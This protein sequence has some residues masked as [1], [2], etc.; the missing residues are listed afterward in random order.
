M[1]VKV[2][3]ARGNGWLKGI[4]AYDGAITRI[5]LPLDKNGNLV[6]GLNPEDEERLEKALFL[7]KGDLNRNSPFWTTKT[8][9]IPANQILILDTDTPEHELDYLILKAQRKVAKSVAELNTGS[10]ASCEFV[11]FNDDEEA[12]SENKRG[13]NKRMAYALFDT[14]SPNEM[15]DIL[16]VYGKPADS[17]S[18]DVV[19]SQL[20]KLLE[21]DPA[22]FLVH[23]NDPTK[24]TRVF[25]LNLVRAGILAK[26]GP[27]YTMYGTD[28]IL[29]YSMEEL[30]KYLDAKA[31][32]GKLLELKE[33]LKN[34]Q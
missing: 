28:E 9:D 3:K 26:K 2:K 6:T 5:G 29:A 8:V 14:L 31:N 16:L 24:K 7:A 19:E 15:R 18:N 1:I 20:Q 30:I 17:S 27:A 12:A 25:V 4:K 10:G 21:E 23:A 33:A 13:K 22:L 32:N 34:R 11:M